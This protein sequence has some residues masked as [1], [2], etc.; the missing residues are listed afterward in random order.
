MKNILFSFSLVLSILFIAGC[1]YGSDNT[2][3]SISGTVATG[4]GASA[5]VTL[6]GFNG[7]TVEGVS[8]NEGAFE[9]VTTGL[10]QPI[11]IRA[12]LDRDGT[13]LYSFASSLRGTANITPLTSFIVDEVAGLLG[14]EGGA[15]QLFAAFQH[16]I[17]PSGIAAYIDSQSEALSMLISSVMQDNNVSGFNHFS[18]G[19]IADH[20][21]YDAVLDDLDIELYEDDIIIR[22][23]AN[24]TLDT[25]NYDINVSNIN[26][27]GTV[28]DV[29]TGNPINGATI[30][31][32]DSSENNIASTTDV[33][34]TF[35]VL[36]ET[37]RIYDVTVEA[38]GYRTQFI[39]GVPSFVFTET[40]IGDIPMFPENLTSTTLLSGLIFDGRTTN[41]GVAA[42]LTFRAGYNERL[43]TPVLV[44]NS[45]IDG[46]DTTSLP[47]GVYTVEISSNHYYTSFET[48]VVYGGTQSQDFAIYANL[49]NSLLSNN[50]LA[51]IILSWGENPEDIDSHLTGPETSAVDGSRFHLYYINRTIGGSDSASTCENGEIASLDRDDVTSF[52]PETTSLC[53]VEAGGLY[54][55]Y[56]H[57]FRGTG[58]MSDGHATVTVATANGTSRTYTAPAE[59]ITGVNDIW[60]VFNI[61]SYGNVYP[62]NLIIGNDFDSSTLFNKA[63]F[64]SDVRFDSESGLFD[65]LPS[66]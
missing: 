34:G 29:T 32:V 62:V 48:V 23:D 41:T 52:G 14:L 46:Y 50:A 54:K 27:T 4:T 7:A 16:H 42:T 25:L 56:V 61:D 55:Y 3:G 18:D 28:V 45:T 35:T 30:T 58:T 57:H 38:T 49:S 43:A 36:V 66:K 40:S 44:T 20:T 47:D 12:V 6:L 17:A 65:D 10:T 63:S 11:I 37:M 15:S 51:T 60:H 9:V 39:P 8:S 22:V 1:D 26:I 21:G 31:L 5:T 53:S 59:G 33:N 24:T 19:F 13:T 2:E 64:S